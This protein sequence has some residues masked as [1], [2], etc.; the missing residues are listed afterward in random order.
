MAIHSGM[1]DSWP[2][3]D[4][5]AMLTNVRA[6]RNRQ[7]KGGATVNDPLGRS[8]TGVNFGDL[9]EIEA[10]LVEAIE[11]KNGNNVESTV[12]NLNL[13]QK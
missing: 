4:L 10:A 2:L 8:R 12:V 5:N 9:I 13:R 1:Y 6:E 7:L 3:A 11:K